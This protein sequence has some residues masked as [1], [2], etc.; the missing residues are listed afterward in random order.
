VVEE[1]RKTGGKYKEHRIPYSKKAFEIALVEFIV[2]D[3]QVCKSNLTLFFLADSPQSLNIIESPRLRAIFFML[4][5][6]LQES[7][8]P[9]RTTI[10]NRIEE[11]FRKNLET[12]QEVMKVCHIAGLSFLH[13]NMV[14]ECS[15]KNLL[16]NR[17]L[18]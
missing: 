6:E 1:Y 4:H 10:R 11:A 2:G 8:I 12:M 18:E 16:H 17:Y 3:D 14:V 9:G 7:D 13:V 15:W 5:A